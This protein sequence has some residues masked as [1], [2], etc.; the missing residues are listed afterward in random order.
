MSARRLPDFAGVALVDILANGMAMLIIVIVL[1]LAAREEHEQRTAEQVKELE[2]MMSRRFSTSLVLNS[3]AASPP[4]R[5]HDYEN[6]PIDQNPDP[7]N[8]PII[9]LHRT[10]VRDLHS[11]TVWSRAQLLREPN[12]MDAWLTTFD[13]HQK[14]RLR[15][16]VYDVAQFYLTMSILRD[17]GIRVR[18]W[19]FLG[20]GKGAGVAGSGDGSGGQGS[21][22]A[23]VATKDCAGDNHGEGTGGGNDALD[24]LAGGGNSSAGGG[25]PAW[26]PSEFANPQG[27]GGNA[28]SSTP[29]P[30]GA[31]I[32][33]SSG[34]AGVGVGT[35]SL[36]G[37]SASFPNARAGGEGLGQGLLGGLLGE[38]GQDG[39]T[40][41]RL[42]NPN[43]QQPD[44]GGMMRGAPP[45]VEHIIAALLA[46]LGEL[47]ATLDAG[48]SPALQ[49]QGFNQY[50]Q[51]AFASP[52]RLS[53]DLAQLVP[54][55]VR[56]VNH[57]LPATE[58]ALRIQRLEPLQ[59]NRR[60]LIV[61]PNRRLNRVSVEAPDH[62]ALPETGQ[63]LLRVNSQP[64]I[65]QGLSVNLAHNSMILLPPTQKN[66]AK[67]G[68]RAM[69][70]ISPELDDFII[71]FVY[72][73]VTPQDL[74]VVQG[75]D[76]RVRIAQ[77]GLD[78]P[79]QP[80]RFGVRNW[81][82][83]LYAILVLGMFGLLALPRL[84]TRIRA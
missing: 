51:R 66:R 1:S 65:W 75:A 37:G 19:H 63:P 73:T 21:C 10:Y 50:L 56:E 68:W 35:G 23:G 57:P 42:A 7:Y 43:T 40:R 82:T 15:V 20:Y 46:F 64:D 77:Y 59:P 25:R 78:I 69:A 5:L 70:H 61:E 79:Y 53:D 58:T 22:P 14:Q 41:F 6:S 76:N 44:S 29:F 31:S 27:G 36:G 81:Q 4:A 3:L 80:P 67:L 11:G 71:G 2:T 24:A 45:S 12:S 39:L 33:G 8:L 72:A 16:D 28:E 54:V 34:L 38:G 26:P 60:T 9:E 47:Q 30:G 62:G 13:Q 83:L 17:H 84:L 49:L 32:G 55:L 52:P 18:H 74:L 48:A